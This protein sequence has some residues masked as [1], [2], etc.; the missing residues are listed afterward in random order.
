VDC[1]PEHNQSDSSCMPMLA[2]VDLDQGDCVCYHFDLVGDC[3]IEETVT[4]ADIYKVVLLPCFG[5][6]QITS[7]H[8]T[9]ST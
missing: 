7:Q 2:D 9:S 1:G 6:P 4:A 5:N 3:C 8:H